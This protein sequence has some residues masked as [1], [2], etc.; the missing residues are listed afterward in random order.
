MRDAQDEILTG[1]AEHGLGLLDLV[2]R[3]VELQD[4]LHAEYRLGQPQLKAVGMHVA[5]GRRSGGVAKVDLGA[6]S[7]YLSTAGIDID[8][9]QKQGAALR[10]LFQA[11]L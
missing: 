2:F 7:G 4:V 8:G 1:L 3:L 5:H 10:Q 11:G 9:R 6:R